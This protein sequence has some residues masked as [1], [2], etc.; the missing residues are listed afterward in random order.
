MGYSEN[1]GDT[2]LIDEEPLFNPTWK[3]NLPSILLIFI[4]WVAWLAHVMDGDMREWGVSATALSDGRYET[5]V[6]HMFAH[7]GAIHIVMNSLALYQLGGLVVLRLGSGLRSW[8]K[9]YAILGLSGIGG[10]LLF[11]A[12]HPH[13]NVPMLGA[14]G[15]I[16]GLLGFLVRAPF[17]KE[18]ISFRSVSMFS[19]AKRLIAEN[20][21]LILLFTVPLLLAGKEGGIAWEAHLGGFLVGLLI[22]PYVVQSHDKVVRPTELH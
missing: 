1:D 21:V 2:S 5:L 4:F 19:A 13:G 14:S 16:Y 17:H 9:A 20:L 18:L 11:L 10:M 3:D 22:A 15:A 7:G 12:F 8:L 6:L